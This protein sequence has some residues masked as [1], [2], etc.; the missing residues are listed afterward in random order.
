M[1]S[2]SQEKKNECCD[3]RKDIRRSSE[4]LPA[5]NCCGGPA[6]EQVDACCVKDAAAKAAG[7]S[8]CGCT[9]ASA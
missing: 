5:S 4:A 8:G 7:A 9:A 6:P 1:Q 3:P 2:V